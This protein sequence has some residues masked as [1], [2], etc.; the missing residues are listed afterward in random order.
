MRNGVREMIMR[1]QRIAK[2]SS[3]QYPARGREQIAACRGGPGLEAPI[4]PGF[5]GAHQHADAASALGAKHVRAGV[6]DEI[7][8]LQIEMKPARG[9]L[10]HADLGLAAGA[11]ARMAGVGVMR[12]IIDRVETSAARGEL[13]S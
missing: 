7:A 11:D 2:R 6:A 12:A 10:Q 9:G 3:L 5:A 1:N 4:S 8:T 13:A